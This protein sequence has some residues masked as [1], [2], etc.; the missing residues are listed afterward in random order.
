MEKNSIKFINYSNKGIFVNGT[1]SLVDNLEPYKIIHFNGKDEIYNQNIELPNDNEKY[2]LSV[3]AITDERELLSYNSVLIELEKEK[4]PESDK[5]TDSDKTDSDKKTD[6]GTKEDNNSKSSGLPG[7]A[8]ALII[9]LLVLLAL[10]IGFII[11]RCIMKRKGNVVEDNSKA[12]LVS[13]G[14]E[15]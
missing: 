7:W 2:F 15:E 12:K 4:E 1:I 10:A 14:D 11:F 5:K 13:I 3:N 9:V 6:S 8:L